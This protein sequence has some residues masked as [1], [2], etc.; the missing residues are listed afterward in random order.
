MVSHDPVQNKENVIR[1]YYGKAD[2]LDKSSGDPGQKAY[3]I[4]QQNRKEEC[5]MI[6]TFKSVKI[7]SSSSLT[8]LFNTGNNNIY[9]KNITVSHGGD[10]FENGG[11]EY[12][13]IIHRDILGQS[14][15]GEDIKSAPMTNVGWDNGYEKRKKTFKKNDN[16]DKIVL[17]EI[18]NHYR[19]D[20]RNYDTTLGY[21]IRKECDLLYPQPPIYYCTADDI[22]KTYS[23]NVCTTDHDHCWFIIGNDSYCVAWGHHN[24]LQTRHHPC[25]GH[26]VGYPIYNIDISNLDIVKYKNL[27]YWNYLD[28]STTTKYDQ[29]G[30][31]PIISTTRYAY[32]NPAHI[33][34][35]RT[36]TKAS[37]SDSLKS[38]TYYPQDVQNQYSY[39]DSL[40]S[41]YRIAEK[42]KE[43]KY[44]NGQIVS[45]MLV[46]YNDWGNNI[47]KPWYISSSTYSN[48]LEPRSRFYKIDNTN[49]N[50]LEFSKEDDVHLSYVWGYQKTKPVIEGKGVSFDD[51]STAV[52]LTNSNLDQLLSSTGI[53]DLTL[54]TQRDDWRE[55]NKNLRNQPLLLNAMITT[56]TYKPLVGL[57]STTDPN[58]ITTY[59]EYDTYGRLIFVRDNDYNIVKK[60]DYHY[61][62]Q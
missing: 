41:H 56:Y 40:I 2:S 7:L 61:A 62:G 9:Y 31:N 10:N 13:Y 25:Y 16:G 18:Y 14:I 3:Y 33:Q 55:F 54:Q 53:G 1:Y 19:T 30:F 47:Y 59:Y 57:S 15:L 43:E 27:S 38:K 45:T 5:E 46:K 42:I 35:T 8:P 32:D 4:T 22:S 58:G 52:N 44:V 48:P 28:Y 60:Y 36:E 51:L 50:P 34:L 20:N 21:S 6:A 26:T 29:N 12:E 17:E 49:W 24:E 39:M 37:N 11:E 23:Y